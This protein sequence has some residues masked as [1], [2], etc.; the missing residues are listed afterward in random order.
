MPGKGGGD[1]DRGEEVREGDVRGIGGVVVEVARNVG[2]EVV[3]AAVGWWVER[4]GNNRCQ[5][6]SAA[7]ALLVSFVPEEINRTSNLS[8][9]NNALFL[10]FHRTS[11]G[12]HIRAQLFLRFTILRLCFH[13]LPLGTYYFCFAPPPPRSRHFLFEIFTVFVSFSP[14]LCTPA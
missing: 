7:A 6:K 8:N 4:V 10:R 11:P 5:P 14:A 13:F 9:A 2:G 3:V 12:A 1:T